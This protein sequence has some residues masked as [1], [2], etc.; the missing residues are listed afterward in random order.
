MSS[1]LKAKGHSIVVKANTGKLINYPVKVIATVISSM[2]LMVMAAM[3]GI[4]VS[5]ELDFRKV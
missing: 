5:M 2:I 3:I 4:T 1:L